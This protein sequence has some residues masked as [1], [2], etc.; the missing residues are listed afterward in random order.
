MRMSKEEIASFI[1]L[2]T[3]KKLME[4]RA[5]AM[6]A[7]LRLIMET[8]RGVSREQDAWMVS[9]AA[10]YELLDDVDAMTFDPVR[11]I[12]MVNDDGSR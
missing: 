3:R 2:D 10:K 5:A 12:A 1:E 7:D 9:F 6:R 4:A 8:I 11:G